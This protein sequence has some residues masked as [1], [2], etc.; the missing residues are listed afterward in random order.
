M[1]SMTYGGP[2]F[3][4]PLLH[5]RAQLLQTCSLMNPLNKHIYIYIN[6]F[7]IDLSIYIYMYI[8]KP[9][10]GIHAHAKLCFF[11]SLCH[12]QICL[13][14][15]PMAHLRLLGWSKLGPNFL[16]IKGRL[17]AKNQDMHCD[18]PLHYSALAHSKSHWAHSLANRQRL[19]L[20]R[21]QKWPIT[22]S[23]MHMYI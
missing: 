5:V 1:I 19:I 20:W 10:P 14:A 13:M 4:G 7:L 6:I 11:G 8:H 23:D 17:W 16:P 3:Q 22:P 2:H 12:G 21:K 15:G 9:R 18:F